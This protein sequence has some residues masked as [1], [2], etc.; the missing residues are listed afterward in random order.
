MP[1]MRSWISSLV[2][3]AIALSGCRTRRPPDLTP[4]AD[5]GITGSLTQIEDPDVEVPSRD[6][7]FPVAPPRTIRDMADVNY[8]DITLEDT[9]RA[10]LVNSKV[11]R[12]LGGSVVRAPE[13]TT[14]SLDPAIQETD[15]RFGVEGAL[16]AFDAQLESRIFSER[17]DRRLNNRFLGNLGVLRGD[18]F[19]WD[20][21]ISKNS[22]GGS[23]FALRQ[24]IDMD[25]DNN[26]GNQFTFPDDAWTV[27][28][29]GE[30][31][32]SILQGGG[33][34]FNRIAGPNATPGLS[35]GV[36]I[37]RIRTDI[38]LADFEIA[39]RDF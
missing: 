30:Y 22:A 19:N 2:V 1:R 9:V 17:I 23:R 14:T 8:W 26:P 36:L 29:E 21:E 32:H 20:T 18:R 12:D 13:T 6:S 37:A 5:A 11:L 15:P 4:Y 31:R 39:L 25:R 34:N 38:S 10:A 33:I 3:I 7:Q 24:H 35:N 27:W 28:Y 16:S